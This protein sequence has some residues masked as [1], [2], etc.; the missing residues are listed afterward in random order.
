MIRKSSFGYMRGVVRDL[1]RRNDLV[2]VVVESVREMVRVRVKLLN[3]R[4]RKVNDGQVKKRVIRG[5]SDK[6]RLRLRDVLNSVVD[7]VGC[8][9]LTYPEWR[10]PVQAK[11]D[12]DNFCRD[13]RRRKV[14]YVWVAELQQRGVIHFHMVVNKWL[15]K[16]WVARRWFKIVKSGKVEHLKA[17]TRVSG[18]ISEGG[19]NRYLMKYMQKEGQKDGVDVRIGRW[20]GRSKGAIKVEKKIVGVIDY[21]TFG[22]CTRLV[23][24]WLEKRVRGWKWM[25]LGLRVFGEMGKYLWGQM[26]FFVEICAGLWKTGG[27][28]IGGVSCGQI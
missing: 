11:R 13:L 3:S 15:D 18:I 28:N 1:G 23:R 9:D 8:V 2:G 17:G 10:D 26:E 19:L 24:R 4:R 14:E 25:G 27:K 5:W 21:R 20:W 12:L 22:R 6:S 7:M 16:D